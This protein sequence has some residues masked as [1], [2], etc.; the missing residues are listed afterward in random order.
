MGGTIHIALG[1]A[2]PVHVPEGGDRL[3][4]HEQ[5]SQH[6]DLIKDMRD[7]GKYILT[8]QYKLTWNNT[9][10]QWVPKKYTPD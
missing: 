2:W 5:S 7:P 3:Q 10:R 4:L 9:T 8:D 1:Q 6:W